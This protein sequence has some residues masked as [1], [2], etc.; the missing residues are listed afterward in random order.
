M[1]TRQTPLHFYVAHD[2]IRKVSPETL[3]AIHRIEA[4]SVVFP[5]HLV[6]IVV[7][8]GKP[9]LAAWSFVVAS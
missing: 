6:Y 8:R 9:P 2:I 3:L 7:Y 5:L 1:G 4:V